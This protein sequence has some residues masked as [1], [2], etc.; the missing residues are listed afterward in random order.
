MLNEVIS[1]KLLTAKG[2]IGFYPAASVHQDD[3]EVYEDESRSKP[4]A[5]FYGLRQQAE[6]VHKVYAIPLLII[7]RTPAAFTLLM[8]ILLLQKNQECMIILVCLLF[9]FLEWTN[10]NRN[11]KKN[12]MITPSSYSRH[13]LIVWYDIM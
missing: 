1:K 6:N 12:T 8:V 5:T 9:P 11:T 10:L 13:L 3:I 4:V 2:V 7:P